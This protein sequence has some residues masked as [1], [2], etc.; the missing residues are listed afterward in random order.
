MVRT[1]Q[2]KLWS[3]GQAGCV[4]TLQKGLLLDF[5]FPSTTQSLEGLEPSL[6]SPCAKLVSHM[7]RTGSSLVSLLTLQ[8]SS[9]HVLVE[10]DQ[11]APSLVLCRAVCGPE[12]SFGWRRLP[13]QWISMLLT[14]ESH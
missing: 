8:F 10:L 5:P 11:L 9:V 6:S 3:L 7:Q 12:C 13:A 1:P 2:R 4:T 14:L